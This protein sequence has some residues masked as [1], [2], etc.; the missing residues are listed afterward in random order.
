MKKG[1]KVQYAWPTAEGMW[2]AY[3]KTLRTQ[4]AP[5]PSL[6]IVAQ[7]YLFESASEN[8]YKVILGGQ[9]GDEAFMGYNKFLYF[10]M[11]SLFKEKSYGELTNSLIFSFPIMFRQFMNP[12]QFIKVG[13]RYFNNHASKNIFCVDDKVTENFSVK[14]EKDQSLLD[15]QLLDITQCSLPTLLRYEDRNSL[16][17]SIETRLPLM[18]YRI[19]EFGMALPVNLKIHKATSK[20]IFRQ[21]IQSYSTPELINNRCKNGFNAQDAYWI[22]QGFGK[23]LRGLLDATKTRYGQ[24]LKEDI[25]I[26]NYFSDKRLSDSRCFA[27]ATT[28]FWLSQLY[29]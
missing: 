6:S 14:F 21:A 12:R 15:R 23:K 4:D 10:N 18:D 22:S 17:N 13:Q 27:E 16:G 11:L 5:F 19:V 3:L 8:G 9:G 7:H 26:E 1:I 2:K 29:E 20:W 28:L 25:N 24:F